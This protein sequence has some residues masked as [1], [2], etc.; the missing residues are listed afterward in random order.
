MNLFSLSGEVENWVRRVTGWLALFG[1]VPLFLMLVITFIDTIGAKI[2]LKPVP[3][4]PE[5][6]AALQVLAITSAAAFLHVSGGHI[7]IA[8]FVERLARRTRTRLSIGIDLLVFILFVLLFWK[9]WDLGLSLRKAG[10]ITSTAHLPL[11]PLALFMCFCFA[12]VSLVQ[13]AQI[14]VKVFKKGK[15]K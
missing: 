4:A 2:F 12:L 3:G 8:F 9:C 1:L 13:L 15:T 14:F 6:V 11:Y 10:E 7:G 5:I